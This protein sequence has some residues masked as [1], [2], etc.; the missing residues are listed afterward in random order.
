MPRRTALLALPLA[1][2]LA[3]APTTLTSTASAAPERDERAADVVLEGRGF[4]HG[5]GLSQYGARAA[6]AQGRTHQ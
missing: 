1:A 6:A 5:K 3:T 2:L 4:G